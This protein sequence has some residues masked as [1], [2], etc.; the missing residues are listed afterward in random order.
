[1]GQTFRK[2]R[3]DTFNEAYE[4][5][6]RALGRRALVLSTTEVKKPGILGLLGQKEVELTAAVP[7][8]APDLRGRKRSAAE[9]HYGGQ[10]EQFGSQDRVDDTVAY[11]KKVLSQAQAR[12]TRPSTPP[13]R[14]PKKTAVE[15][16]VIPFRRPNAQRTQAGA[17][18]LR[19]DMHDMRNML[20]VLVAETQCAGLPRAFGPWYRALATRGVSRRLAADVLRSVLKGNESGVLRNQGRFNELLE[21]EI[22]ARVSVNGGIAVTP[23]TRRT[24]A[25][26]GATGV[27][28]TTNLAKLA[29]Q[30]AVRQ[31][32]HVALLTVDTYR[33]AAPEQLRV[34]ANIIGLPM[35]IAN[36]P[37]EMASAMYAFRDHDLV[38]I[39]TAGSSQFNREQIQELKALLTVAQPQETLLVLSANTQLA[40]SRSVVENFA[41]LKPTALLFSKLDETQQYGGLFSLHAETGL[42]LSYFSVGQDVPQDIE[43]ATADKVATLILETGES[44]VR[45][46]A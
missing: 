25:L 18:T 9:R 26:V 38:L 24:V 23:G 33:I 22:R 17:D 4:E 13:P 1:M 6:A 44:R 27:G 40:E 30:F 41:G 14:P 2:F 3:A 20:Q 7:T 35:R 10:S 28:K 45:S 31:R 32:L 37:K 5:M 39:D 42:P 12:V 21:R 8:P 15:T 19:Q 43:L 11:F 29:A 46:S 34:Y 36:D 16:P